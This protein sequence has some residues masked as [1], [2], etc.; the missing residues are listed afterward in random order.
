M[1]N[2]IK[3]TTLASNNFGSHAEVV[4]ILIE[5]GADVN[6]QNSDGSSALMIGMRMKK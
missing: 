5:H 3:M 2:A 6:H 1:N 4:D